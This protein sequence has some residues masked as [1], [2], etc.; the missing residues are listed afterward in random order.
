MMAFTAKRDML[1]A[2]VAGLVVVQICGGEFEL[3]LGG[4]GAVFRVL[5]EV[6]RKLRPCGSG[7]T[8][9][10]FRLLKSLLFFFNFINVAASAQG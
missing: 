3:E 4:G 2:M 8:G 1:G 7:M 6:V 10:I 9:T 5:V